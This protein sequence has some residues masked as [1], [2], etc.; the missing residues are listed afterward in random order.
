MSTFLWI[1][2]FAINALVVNG[3]GIATIYKNRRWAENSKEYFMCFAAGIL[4]SSPLIMTLPEALEKNHYAGL[5]ALA[6][7]LFMYFINKIVEHKHEK[8]MAFGITAIIGILIHSLF[9]GVIYTVTFNSSLLLGLA[10]GVGLVA[11]EFAEGVITFAMLV[12]AGVNHKKAILWAF[13]VASLTT[14][15]GAFVAY[16]FVSQFSEGQTGLSLGFVAGVLIYVS[17]SHL[18]P[19][20]SENH[21]EHSRLALILGVSFSLLMLLFGGHSH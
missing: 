11:H 12:K 6:G 7:F 8:N 16:P 9:D 10:A 13:L 4:I 21:K 15:I 17:A 14:P 3:L 18:L 20:A 5:A 1:A 19:E 2:I